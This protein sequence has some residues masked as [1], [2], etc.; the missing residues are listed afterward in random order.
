M[1][2]GLFLAQ[3]WLTLIGIVVFGETV[4]L[5]ALAS[6]ATGDVP[7]S[8]VVAMAFAG[9]MLADLGWFVAAR[10]GMKR[11]ATADGQAALARAAARI[12]RLGRPELAMIVA[13]FFYGTRIAAI[14]ALASSGTRMSRF[15]AFNAI[16]TALWLAILVP[17]GLGI[18]EG[19]QTLGAGP[20]EVV[21]GLG[22]VLG[23]VWLIR[24]A[25]VLRRRRAESDGAADLA[26][27]R[28]GGV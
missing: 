22:G 9:T 24:G 27:R 10:R 8:A 26:G 12:Q 4:I 3:P 17:V 19:L 2:P 13:K 21:A 20:L 28:H 25:G 18:G 23:V 11:W 16:G 7:V 6:A 5:A 14:V 15:A 1:I